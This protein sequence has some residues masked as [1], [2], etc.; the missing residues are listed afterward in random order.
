MRQIES[1]ATCTAFVRYRYPVEIMP[2]MFH[3]SRET[4]VQESLVGPF[5]G[6]KCSNHVVFEGHLFV[7]RREGESRYICL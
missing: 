4:A 6:Q 7:G 3:L 1:N 2:Q 5:F